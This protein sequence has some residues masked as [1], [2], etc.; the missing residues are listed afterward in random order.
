MFNTAKTYKSQFSAII[1]LCTLILCSMVIL[2]YTKKNAS[3]Q[4]DPVLT[5]DRSYRILEQEPL[6][7]VL[8]IEL[9]NLQSADFPQDFGIQVTNLTQ[10]PIYKVNA[11]LLFPETKALRGQTI[12]I[13]LDFGP[14][15]LTD[16]SQRSETTD[17]SIKPG[18]SAVLRPKID[19]MKSLIKHLNSASF[20]PKDKITKV[21]VTVKVISFGDGTGYSAGEPSPVK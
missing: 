13:R 7:D 11:L 15:R 1:A 14:A 5:K 8:K 21:V 17:E 16:I 2:L 20:N 10:K 12:G 9:Q 18:A 19:Q 6:K 3:A 4:A